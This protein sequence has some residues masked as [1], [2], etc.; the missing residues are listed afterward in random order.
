ML[1]VNNSHDCP[2][3]DCCSMDVSHA[4]AIRYRAN[5]NMWVDAFS[6][7]NVQSHFQG[8]NDFKK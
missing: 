3:S 2:I 8:Q 4:T 7:F 6:G 1:A 5:I